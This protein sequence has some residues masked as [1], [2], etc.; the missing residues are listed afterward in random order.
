VA[1]REL[2]PEDE[3]FKERASLYEL[4]HKLVQYRNHGG[5]DPLGYGESALQLMRRLSSRVDAADRG[6]S[7]RSAAAQS[8]AIS[9]SHRSV[10]TGQSCPSV[11]PI[12][13]LPAE[14]SAWLER[15]H[16]LLEG[17]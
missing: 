16:Q 12:R 5:G 13:P 11:R 15:W 2:I 6:R 4:Y 10:S 8:L 9:E 1:T 17:W 3:G 7:L 14:A